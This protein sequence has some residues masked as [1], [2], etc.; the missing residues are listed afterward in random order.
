MRK[1]ICDVPDCGKEIR[2]LSTRQKIKNN[3][4]VEIGNMHACAECLFNLVK[5][6]KKQPQ[7]N[8]EG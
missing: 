7:Q 8:A 3:T 6:K 2:A 4:G 5:P 1:I